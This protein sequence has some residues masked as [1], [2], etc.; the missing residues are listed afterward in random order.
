MRWS[1]RAPSRRP[2]RCHGCPKALQNSG[3]SCIG[4]P[5]F[6]GALNAHVTL[7]V[8]LQGTLQGAIQHS[9]PPGTW[10]WVQSKDLAGWQC[11]LGSRAA[12]PPAMLGTSAVSESKHI[13]TFVG[14]LGSVVNQ[15]LYHR[16]AQH[17]IVRVEHR[18]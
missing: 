12:A 3:I 18:A 5:L 14:P 9:K 4:R 8:T 13:E 16:W 7:Q 2:S 10:A 15:V 11:T 17:G 6:R 1:P